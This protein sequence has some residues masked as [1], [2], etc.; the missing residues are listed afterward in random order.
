MRPQSQILKNETDI[1][2]MWGHINSGSFG[3]EE[4]RAHLDCAGPRRDQTGDGGQKRRLSRPAATPQDR[5][6]ARWEFCTAAIQD[7]P[8]VSFHKQIAD[9][10]VSHAASTGALDPT[11]PGP[12]SKPLR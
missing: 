9:D 1:T 6:S 12:R 11:Q 8:L 7:H 2:F 10:K 3:K 4:T 5:S